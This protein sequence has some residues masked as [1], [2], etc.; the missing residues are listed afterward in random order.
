MPRV[1]QEVTKHT[2]NICPGSKPI[3]QGMR[4]FKQEKHRAMG[5]EL[6]NLFAAS[7]VKEV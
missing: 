3:K 6:F 5:E 4:H 7:F 1:S 2:L